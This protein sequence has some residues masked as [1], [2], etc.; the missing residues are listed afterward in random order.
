MNVNDLRREG[1]EFK[2]K[3][4]AKNVLSLIERYPHKKIKVLKPRS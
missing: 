3:S 2:P 4:Q 1:I